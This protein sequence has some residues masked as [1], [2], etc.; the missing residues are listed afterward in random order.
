MAQ[1]RIEIV[2][3]ALT[4]LAS[5]RIMALSDQQKSAKSMDAV[6]AG[7]RDSAQKVANWNFAIQRFNPQLLTSVPVFGYTKEFQI[8]ADCLRV[9]QIHDQYIGAPSLGPRYLSESPKPD[10]EIE[11]G[12][13]LTDLS[14]PLNCRGVFRTTNEAT[15]D[16]L[17][18][19]FFIE[20][21]CIAAAHDLTRKG[22]AD[23]SAFEQAR[24]RRLSIAQM[25]DAI[26][27]PPQEIPD[28]SWILSRVGP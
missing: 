11:G 4:R 28:T 17:F 20:E 25:N 7:T 16:P 27:Q 14:A 12:K 10:F 24:D 2:N 1:D 23:V 8:D 3:R 13:I 6:Y 22:A 9:I 5:A 26:E 15:W 21:L 19:D 18:I